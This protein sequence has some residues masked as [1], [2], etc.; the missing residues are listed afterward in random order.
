MVDF[1]YRENEPSFEQ[2]QVINW[3]MMK[4][5]QLICMIPEFSP[6]LWTLGV[7]EATPKDTVL[8][9]GT[10]PLV[11]PQTWPK[12]PSGTPMLGNLHR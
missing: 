11:Y 1:P 12:K 7:L 9:Q 6:T 10:I 2:T 5:S 8:L 3:R 4:I